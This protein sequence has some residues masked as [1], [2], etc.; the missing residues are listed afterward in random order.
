[1]QKIFFK[2]IPCFYLVTISI[3][4]F[5]QSL[6]PIGNTNFPINDNHSS[7]STAALNSGWQINGIG[8][9]ITI[10]PHPGIT[11]KL[12][13]CTGSGGI[14][15]TTNSGTSWLPLSGSF[16]PG[17]QFSCLSIDPT[18]TNIMYAGSGESTYAQTYGWGGYG[19]FKSVNGGASWV[20]MNTGMGNLVVLDI[21]V[22]PTNTQ[23]VVACTRDGLYKTVNGGANWTVAYS[24]PNQWMQQILRQSGNVLVAISN[25]RFYRSVDWGTSWTA[26][27][28]DPAF[29]STFANGKI[30]VA[31][32]NPQVVYAGWVNNTF[33]TASN[34]CIFY[35]TDG[36]LT[37]TKKYAFADP[38][39]V[40]SYDGTSTTGYGWANFFLSVLPTDPNTL[41]TGGHLIFRSTNNG[42][43]WTAIVPN[44]WCCIHTDI[45][46]FFFDPATPGRVLTSTD[47]GVFAT[48]DMGINWTQVSNG[49]YCNQYLSMGQGNLDPNFVIGGLQDNGIIYN[50]ID[51]NYHTYTGGDLY[52]HMTCDYTNSYNVYTSY[53]GGRVF[54][55]YNRTQRA[56]LN[57]PANIVTTGTANSRQ[58]FVLTPLDPTIAYGWGTNIFR[59]SNINSYNIATNTSS[60]SWTQIGTIG[61]TIRDLKI[62][63]NS[64]AVVYAIANNATVYKSINATAVTPVFTPYI[65]PAG[66]SSSVTGSLT[67]STLNPN[68]LYASANNQVYRSTNGGQSW[69]NYTATGLPSINFQKVF[70][71]PYSSIEGVYL[72]TTL[73]VYYRDLTMAAWSSVN[74][75]VPAVQQNAT[76]SY[77]GLINGTSLYKG[78]GSSTSHVS[79]ATWG[80]G[81]WK[82]TF[83]DQLNGALPAVWSSEDI[84]T[85]AIA[86]NATY[87]N[88]KQTFNLQ[89]SGSG[90]N[91]LS[92]D[93][94]NFTKTLLNGNGDLITKVYSVAET[95]ITN[96]LSKT[97]LML[98]SSN[99]SNAPYVMVSLTGHAGAI[100]QY[101]TTTGAVAVITAVAPPVSEPYPYWLKLNKTGNLITA[102]TSV[103]GTT[104]V[105]AGQTTVDLGT[106]FL[107]GAAST[108]NNVAVANKSAISNIVIAGFGVLQVQNLQLNARLKGKYRVDLS[109]SFESDER[110]N[111]LVLE[112]STDGV[113]FVEIHQA[114]YQNNN[115]SIH[116]FTD[117]KTDESPLNGNNYYRVKIVQANGDVKYSQV[118]MVK[119]KGSS[120]VRIDPN[121]VLTNSDLYV[122][123]IGISNNRTISF[124]IFD[125]AGKKMQSEKLKNQSSNVVKLNLPAG[126]YMYRATHDNQV[127]SGKF[128]VIN[129]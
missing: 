47:G 30:A 45:R 81:I 26:F 123:F 50:N 88:I 97:G 23:E 75:N 86:G 4:C 111:N 1:M 34:A 98:R 54:N 32:S 20:Q 42:S 99:A 41:F 94:F 8:K 122:S 63:T 96:G 119:I 40:V 15:V 49:L 74:P 28:L 44:W 22:N 59:S 68:V 25:T 84:G 82:A 65:L 39:K 70:V 13:A 10:V 36:G 19:T 17:V 33:G 11:T 2:I 115:G 21:L 126:T 31:P 69:T 90:L 52:D 57:L 103:D 113:R 95:D 37:F 9:I 76:A 87:D 106:N 124:D 91:N 128:V 120:F 117:L 6:V 127:S 79:F 109:W 129:N 64:T 93:Q 83:Y 58:S 92:T 85:P 72:I 80:S 67:V 46:Q 89:A 66:A 51:G 114:I 101:R 112:R 16:L 29:S 27:D 107:G 77:G 104:W 102:S 62:S 78:A 5:G 12:Y 100:F 24:A 61:V 7:A 48:T 38:V 71:D 121:P 35:S 118:V 116:S 110:T 53:G 108:S 105:L 3:F 125:M 56:N 55:P 60:V 43:N 73:G 18:N 14:F